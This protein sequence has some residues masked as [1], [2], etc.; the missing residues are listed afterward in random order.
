MHRRRY[1]NCRW[2]FLSLSLVL[3]GSLATSFAHPLWFIQSEYFKVCII[4]PGPFHAMEHMAC[5]CYEACEYLIWLWKERLLTTLGGG[6]T[7][8][9]DRKKNE[10][11]P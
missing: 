6:V 11:G 10:K 2:L 9:F 1:C 7:E 8:S 4:L 3:N 5:L